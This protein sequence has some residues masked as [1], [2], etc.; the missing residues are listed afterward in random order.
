MQLGLGLD[1]VLTCSLPSLDRLLVDPIVIY[2]EN[3]LR[4]PTHNHN[5]KVK[6]ELPKLEYSGNYNLLAESNPGIFITGTIFAIL[7]VSI[8]CGIADMSVLIRPKDQRQSGTKKCSEKSEEC[9]FTCW[10]EIKELILLLKTSISQIAS[11]LRFT[12]YVF[13]HDN[14]HV[15]TTELF[16]PPEKLEIGSFSLFTETS[17]K[18]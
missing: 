6:M 13:M 4:F 7:I 8:Y 3:M 9:V 17:R 12:L 2:T 18:T 16:F 10:E 1:L 14:A 11:T 5:A 15:L